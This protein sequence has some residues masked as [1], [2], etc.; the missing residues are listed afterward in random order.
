MSPE[1]VMSAL[2]PP[3]CTRLRVACWARRRSWCGSRG[4]SVFDRGVSS[5][6]TS[7][8]HPSPQSHITKNTI[9]PLL[10]LPFPSA[11][12]QSAK[13]LKV[14]IM[15]LHHY[16]NHTTRPPSPPHPPAQPTSSCPHRP[17]NRG[18]TS[19]PHPVRALQHLRLPGLRSRERLIAPR[20]P[21]VPARS[22]T[23]PP[24]PPPRRRRVV[25]SRATPQSREREFERTMGWGVGWGGAGIGTAQKGWGR[26]SVFVKPHSWIGK[27]PVSSP[28]LFGT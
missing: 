17:K 3:T 11:R 25:L 19:P 26:R 12:P 8:S 14:P 22:A 18:T 27:A 16:P 4:S 1:C 6:S 24:S 13:S 9:D 2:L 5:S 7:Y 20:T 21:T 15:R 23:S 10:F 28:L